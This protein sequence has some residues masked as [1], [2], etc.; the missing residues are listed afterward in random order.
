MKRIVVTGSVFAL[1]VCALSVIIPSE[2]RAQQKR[3]SYAA[4]IVGTGG[5]I[6]GRTVNLNINI[7]S[8][9]TDQQVQEYLV[10]LREEGQEALRKTL[11]TVKVGRIAPVATTGTDL[12]IARVFQTEQ[13]KVIRLVTPRPVPF[14]EA[15]RHGRSMDYPF[16]IMELRLDKEG[17]GEGSIIGGAQ[18][19]FNEE[20][21]LDIESYG[22]QYAKLVNVRAWD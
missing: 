10:Q 6:G 14:L 15:Y 22:N 4:V 7:D 5:R 2:L 13:G 9:T 16:T 8:Y 1:L 3:E 20:G 11:E 21:Q 18:L 12:S 17:K 19:K